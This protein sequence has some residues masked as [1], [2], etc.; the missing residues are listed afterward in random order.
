[1]VSILLLIKQKKMK[2]Y[3]PETG[4]FSPFPGRKPFAVPRRQGAA[5]KTIQGY[6]QD[7]LILLRGWQEDLW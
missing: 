6:I 2:R 7:V 5:A 3:Q 4:N 1:M